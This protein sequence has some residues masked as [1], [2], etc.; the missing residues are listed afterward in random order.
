[1]DSVRNHKKIK[2]IIYCPLKNGCFMLDFGKNESSLG[3]RN[4][5][6]CEKKRKNN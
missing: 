1:M 6:N 5:E 3:R 4:R 2:K